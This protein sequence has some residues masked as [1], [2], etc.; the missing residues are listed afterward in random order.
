M[1]PEAPPSWEEAGIQHRGVQGIH[2]GDTW[3]DTLKRLGEP[4]LK[5]RGDGMRAWINLWYRTGE[6]AGLKYQFIH[7]QDD[8]ESSVL[9]YVVIKAPYSGQTPEGIGIGATTEQVEAAYGEPDWSN[10]HPVGYPASPGDTTYV[11]LDR[12]Q[13]EYCYGSRRLGINLIEGVVDAIFFGWHGEPIG[14]TECAR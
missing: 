7:D 12:W 9:D 10:F 13:Y 11:L 5:T 2:F 8:Y 6:Y 3:A 1:G 4:D 14:P